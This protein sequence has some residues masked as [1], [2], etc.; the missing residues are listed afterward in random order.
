M[1]TQGLARPRSYTIDG[2]RPN[3]LRRLLN[4]FRTGL[5]WSFAA[6]SLHPDRGV[7][8][9]GQVVSLSAEIVNDGPIMGTAYLR[10]LVAESY[11]LSHP[12]FD[13]DRDGSSNERHA[14]RALDVRPG[15]IREMSCSFAMPAGLLSK[16]FDIRLEIWNPQ[17][18]FR[19]SGARKFFDTGWQGAF[20]VIALPDASPE[21]RVFVSYSWDS[22]DHQQWVRQ[23][24]EELHRHDIRA[25]FDRNDL[26]PGEDASL[27]MERGIAQSAVTLLICTSTYTDKAD[28]RATGG[29]GFETIVSAHE[30]ANRTEE[31]R[32]R[33]IPIV[34][35]NDRPAGRKLPKYLGSSLY[36]DMS[37]ANWR[38][39]PMTELVNAI[40][41]Y[42]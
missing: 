38:G 27:F 31:D 20:E 41:R 26:R 9:D 12:I 35:N 3:M 33:F 39:K 17:R 11:D 8:H 2:E 13:S 15:E 4:L 32:A 21:R 30:Y 10:F 23:L 14:L 6:R 29:V 34:R 7:V 36:V 22:P 25:M 16:H 5:R 28:H 19:K 18:L 37:G 24:V 1:L 42:V 40:R